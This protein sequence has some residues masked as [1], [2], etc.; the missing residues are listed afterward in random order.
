MPQQTLTQKESRMLQA[1][2][3]RYMEG[4]GNREIA[5]ELGLNE[6]TIRNYF[7]S[8]EMEQFE[9]FFSEEAREFLKVQMKQRIEDGTNMA[10]NLLSQAISDDRAKPRTKIKAAKQAQKV[11]ERYIKMMQ[12]LGV[13][14]KP[15]ERKEV[16]KT[17]GSDQVLSDLQEAY[18]ELQEEEE[19]AE[20]DA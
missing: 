9:E 12:E 17:G 5:E 1:A 4:K 20:N 10:D 11:P 2:R 16:E 6:K 19:E 3:M 8:S 14:Q 13:I 15:K 7:T 18:N